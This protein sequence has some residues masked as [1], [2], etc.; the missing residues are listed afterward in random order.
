MRTLQGDLNQMYTQR[1]FLQRHGFKVTMD[2]GIPLIESV[3]YESAVRKIYESCEIGW[4][5]YQ[6]YLIENGICT[7]EEFWNKLKRSR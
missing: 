1:E 7:Q 5:N 2:G 4:W 6:E 3:D